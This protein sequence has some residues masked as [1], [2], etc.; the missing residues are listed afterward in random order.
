MLDRDLVERE[1][2]FLGDAIFLNAAS[3]IMPPMRVQN[4]YNN[5]MADYVRALGVGVVPKGWEIVNEARGRLAALVNCQPHEIAFT[6]NTCEGLSIA[7]A[8]IDVTPGDNAVICDQEHEANIFPWM[9]QDRRGLEL[10]VVPTQNGEVDIDALL[11][12]CDSCTKVLSVSS[13]QFTTGHAVDLRA[14]GA[15]CRARDIIFVV[16]GV[17]TVGRLKIDVKE[18]NIDYLAAGGHKGLLGTLGAGFVYCSDRIVSDLIPPYASYQS[19]VNHT[20]PPALT[21]QFDHLEW[22]SNARRLES[23]TPNF[24]DILAISRGVEL[25]LEL[26]V[27]NIESTIRAL[28]A[29]F[30]SLIANL[31]L[32]A[33][34]P[35]DARRWS[36]IICIYY[37]K[38]TEAQVQA[39]LRKQK[40]LCSMTAG[41]LRFGIEFYNTS[42]QMKRVA[43]ALQ[44]ISGLR[45]AA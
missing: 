43:G 33:V 38:G 3:V 17:Q 10:R 39:I 31:P 32:R 4:A 1:Y 35:A 13:A 22:H 23:G 26:G 7:A 25:I 30:R 12:R 40:I 20:P 24:N 9:N 41:Y 16:D 42:E 6:K 8:A 21:T 27:E 29:E 19:V 44:E 2:G 37:P 15:E 34:Q 28:E 45:T 11:K 14:L 36:G 5:F 18:C